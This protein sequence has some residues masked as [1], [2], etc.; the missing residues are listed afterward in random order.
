M[1]MARI[2]LAIVLVACII[3]STPML[4]KGA[5]PTPQRVFYLSSSQTLSSQVPSGNCAGSTLTCSANLT[6]T[7][8]SFNLLSPLQSP[9]T[10]LGPIIFSLWT[11]YT[12]PPSST[13]SVSISGTF[14]YHYPGGSNSW[15]NTNSSLQQVKPGISNVTIALPMPATGTPLIE[16]TSIAIEIMATQLPK[17]ASISLNWGSGAA[18]SFGHSF[19]IVPMSQYETFFASSTASP[20]SIL[21]K[22]D[23]PT[24]DFS[25]AVSQGNNIILFKVFVLSAMGITDVSRVNMTIVD[26][27]LRPVHGASNATMQLATST[28]PYEFLLSW[29]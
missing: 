15:T 14:S 11:N 29:V 17:N 16:Q 2:G 26:P 12:R 8:L 28:S 6:A 22:S 9:A 1:T 19:V 23:N 3:L 27:N 5:P 21:D 10:I 24:T 20:V 7:P 4:T 18:G 25:L 13:L